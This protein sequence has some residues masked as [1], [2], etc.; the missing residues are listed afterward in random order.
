MWQD[1]NWIDVFEFMGCSDDAVNT[2]CYDLSLDERKFFQDAF[3]LFYRSC[4]H[5]AVTGYA[6]CLSREDNAT[7]SEWMQDEEETSIRV[8]CGAI[9]FLAQRAKRRRGF[10]VCQIGWYS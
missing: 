3:V 8:C 7:L 5:V 10:E 6:H 1:S 2:Y 4:L 9:Y